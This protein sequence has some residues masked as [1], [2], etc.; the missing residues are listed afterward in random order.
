MAG[1]GP[2]DVDVVQLYENFS[3]MVLLD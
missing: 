1:C 3:G 2:G